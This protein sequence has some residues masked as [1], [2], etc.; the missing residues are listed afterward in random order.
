[1]IY[2]LTEIANISHSEFLNRVNWTY[3]EGGGMAADFY[4]STINN[5]AI[6]MGERRMY[7]HT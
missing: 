5:M 2:S 4:A 6:K 3:G 1:M 7:L